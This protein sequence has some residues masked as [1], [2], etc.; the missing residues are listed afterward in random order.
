MTCETCNDTHV[1]PL[2]ERMVPCTRCPTP[3]GSC[4]GGSAYCATTPCLCRC[5]APSPTDIR[6]HIDLSRRASAGMPAELAAPHVALADLCLSYFAALDAADACE[7]TEEALIA[8]SNRLTTAERRLRAALGL[9]DPDA[10]LTAALREVGAEHTPPGGWQD[11]VLA[12]VA[13][14]RSA[15]PGDLSDDDLAEVEKRYADKTPTRTCPVCGAVNWSLQAIGRG[16]ETWAYRGSL[17]ERHGG[18]AGN[19]QDWEH[20]RKS[21]LEVMSGDT[22]I[23]ALLAEV[24]R[25]R[26]E[27][28]N[29]ARQE[30]VLAEVAGTDTVTL[31]FD[32]IELDT[33]LAG[34]ERTLIRAG[35]IA[36][37][38]RCA[39]ARD[40]AHPHSAGE[41]A[42]LLLG[43]PSPYPDRA[44]G[45]RSLTIGGS[46]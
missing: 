29:A 1:M 2:G 12:E 16:R 4:R 31:T 45:D 36:E 46:R 35:R 5:H 32:R 23:A 41:A 42:A 8:S 44:A 3:C 11:R 19:A 15:H 27:R 25:R 17:S 24:R 20:Y 33:R 37:A 43:L 6:E 10:K 26:A 14:D 9:P 39:I 30:R 34:I 7:L 22:R 28:N 18:R 13:A 40:L 38:H 21:N